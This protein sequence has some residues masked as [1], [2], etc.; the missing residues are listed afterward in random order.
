MSSTLNDNHLSSPAQNIAN[1]RESFRNVRG[2]QLGIGTT[3]VLLATMLL[4]VLSCRHGADSQRAEIQRRQAALA[5]RAEY[6]VPLGNLSSRRR[7]TETEAK[8]SEFFFGTVPEPPLGLVKPIALAA[9]GDE[10]LI[11]DSALNAVFTFAGGKLSQLPLRP[12]P[13]KPVG[14]AVANDGRVAVADAG[15]ASVHVYQADGSS[16]TTLRMEDD[17]RPADAAFVGG[18]VWV[19]NAAGNYVE[20]FD[21]ASGT[22]RRTIGARGN[23]RGQFGVPLGMAVGPSSA[24]S[25]VDMLNI[26]VQVFDAAGAWQQMIGRSGD[27]VGSFGRPKDVAVGPD[28]TVFVVDAASQRVHAFTPDGKALLGF[29]EPDGGAG[30]ALSMPAG[31]CVAPLEI[32]EAGRLPSGVRADYLVAV[33]EQLDQPGV[34]LYAWCSTAANE[35]VRLASQKRPSNTRV[36]GASVRNPHWDAG[37]CN[38]CHQMQGSRALPIAANQVDKNCLSCHD[39][40]KASLEP[41]PIG[42]VAQHD[43]IKTPTD[44]PLNDGLLSCI[45]CHDIQRHCN[46]NARRPTVN[47]ALLRYHDPE[48]PMALCTQCHVPTDDWRLS[49]HDQIAADGSVRTNTCTFCHVGEPSSDRSGRRMGIAE[50]RGDASEVC[51]TCHTKHWDYSPEGHVDRLTTPAIRA[52]MAERA[53]GVSAN[54]VQGYRNSVLPLTDQKVTC[55]SCH[56]PHAPGLFPA[57]S[58]LGSYAN[59]A[60]DRAIDLRLDRDELCLSCHLK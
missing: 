39:G 58:Q 37:R 7:L 8:L 6:V 14:I 2:N 13:Q 21:A 23:Q 4:T 31:I 46:T 28:G 57:D 49:P 52:R 17:F 11:C 47:P 27:R 29:G 26:R 54:A 35:A 9:R 16:Q 12:V 51:L 20:V 15:T 41:H 1:G 45:T 44:W 18:D 43:D 33:A 60:A 38:D 5:G 59:N 24:V 34:R 10:L 36:A 32:V 53:G 40:K 30:A 48:Q 19:S 22:H 56:N 42:R 50:L 55:Y 3:L 25:V